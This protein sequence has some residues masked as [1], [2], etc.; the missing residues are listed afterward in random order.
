[1]YVALVIAHSWLRWLVLLAAAYALAKAIG[2]VRSRRPWTPSDDQAG[3]V[4]VTMFDVQ[5]LIGLILY[6]ALSPLTQLAFS[7]FGAAMRQPDLRFWAVEHLTGMVAAAALLHIGRA[8]TRKAAAASKHKTAAIFFGLALFIVLLSI[9]WP[10][11]PAGR[12]L[13]RLP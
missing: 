10:G 5:F 11:M 9:P 6:V 1:M 8:R 12:P 3:R 2:G 7:D 4:F 13:F